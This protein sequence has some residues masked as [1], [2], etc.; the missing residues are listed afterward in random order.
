[1]ETYFLL[2]HGET[3]WNKNG[4]LM[5]RVEVP[6]NRVG[7]VQAKRIA[8]V[9]SRLQIDVIYSSP[10]K[11]ALQT[12]RIVARGAKAPL[13]IDPLLTEVNF[14]RWE[15]YGYE[16]LVRDNS[17]HRFLK[18]PANT[19]I[20]KGET[21]RDVQKRGIK[22]LKRAAEE[23]PGGRLLFVTHAD[24]IR[25]LLCHHLR[26][27]LGEFHRLRIDNG[28]LTGLEVKGPWAECKFINYVPDIVGVSHRPS[29][30]PDPTRLK[31]EKSS[32]LRQ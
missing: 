11:R 17:Y 22:M 27:S 21:L 31:N 12:A 10:L 23:R 25:A 1:M 9:I 4:K 29:M 14:G 18:S 15:G 28:S 24:I 30:G 2:R 3:N 7:I 26:L 16:Q 32:G 20:P 19:K 8:T 13:K 6:L 5:G